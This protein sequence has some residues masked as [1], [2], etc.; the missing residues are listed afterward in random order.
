MGALEIQQNCSHSA[1][2]LDGAEAELGE[3][4]AD[5]LAHRG[6]GECERA[7]DINVRSH[8]FIAG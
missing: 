6:I 2:V 3:N 5:V 4:V 8:G 7:R 1:V